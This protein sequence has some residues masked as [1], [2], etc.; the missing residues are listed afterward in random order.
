MKTEI[1]ALVFYKTGSIFAC[2][3]CHSPSNLQFHWP[4]EQKWTQP[5]TL[6]ALS[7][8]SSPLYIVPA[9]HLMVS[10]ALDRELDK[11]SILPS[12]WDVNEGMA[13]PSFCSKCVNK[14]LEKACPSA[15]I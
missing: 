9:I 14:K 4:L 11:D 2:I 10:S 8:S 12:I 6:K 15:L 13:V 5:L 3:C 1:V 7:H